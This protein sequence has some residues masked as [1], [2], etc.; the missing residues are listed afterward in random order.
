ME[1]EGYSVR[2]DDLVKPERPVMM[3][4]A[5]VAE[6]I[7]RLDRDV[8][9]LIERLHPVLGASHPTEDN[10]V[11]P[12]VYDAGNSELVTMGIGMVEQLVRIR[13]KVNEAVERLEV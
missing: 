11:G 1:P 9:L 4:F 13:H 8:S 12:N 3:R 2:T 6:E 7:E 10:K 5:A